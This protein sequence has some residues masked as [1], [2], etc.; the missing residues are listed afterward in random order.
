MTKKKLKTFILN[1]G[2][3]KKKFKL[4]ETTIDVYVGLLSQNYLS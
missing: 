4:P 1:I 2:G 3:K